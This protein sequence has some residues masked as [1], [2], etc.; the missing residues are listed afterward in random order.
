VTFEEFVALRLPALLRQATVLAGDPHT[1][2]DLVQDVL[3][4][5]HARWDRIGGLDSP[6]AYLRRM[7]VNEVVST[8]RSVVAR[9]RRER[10]QLPQ[11]PADPTAQVDQRA[12]L[13]HLIRALPPRQR[14]VIAL[15][16]FEDLADGDIAALMGCTVANV[17][18]Q[19]SRALAVLRA[20]ASEPERTHD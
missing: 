2:E 18:S 6:E 12:A 11:P 4:K 10:G 17:R 5:A 1:A 16:Y 9:L 15:R 20:A 19:A 13:V 8:R 3:V 14:V 7:L